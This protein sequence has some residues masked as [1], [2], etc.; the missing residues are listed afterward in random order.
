MSVVEQAGGLASLLR[1]T[2]QKNY[3]EELSGIYYF[4]RKAHF[5]NFGFRHKMTWNDMKWHEMSQNDIK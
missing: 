4:Y 1:S 3:P 2:P 5:S